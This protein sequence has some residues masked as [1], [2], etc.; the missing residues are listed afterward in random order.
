MERTIPLLLLYEERYDDECS[1]E[2]CMFDIFMC[3]VFFTLV[4][5]VPR[6]DEAD[7]SPLNTKKKIIR[8]DP[9]LFTFD[10]VSYLSSFS[11]TF[12]IIST[13]PPASRYFNFVLIENT[14][15]MDVISFMNAHSSFCTSSS[16]F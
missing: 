16:T 2:L 8:P 6:L 13:A 7:G 5:A 15:T 10:E 3:N 4:G 1:S 9:S 14:I 12:Y 11:F